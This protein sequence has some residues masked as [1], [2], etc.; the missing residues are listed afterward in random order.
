MTLLILPDAPLSNVFSF[1]LSFFLLIFSKHW[2]QNGRHHKM[3]GTLPIENHCIFSCYVGEDRSCITPQNISI[4]FCICELYSSIQTIQTCI[5]ISFKSGENTLICMHA[6]VWGYPG[7]WY[8]NSKCHQ[9]FL[10]ASAQLAAKCINEPPY[11]AWQ[12]ADAVICYIFSGD[13]VFFIFYFR[14]AIR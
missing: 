10:R 7:T 11:D 12:C 14:D 9:S 8:Q 6:Y 5:S 4:F 3:L 1:F 2:F 13:L